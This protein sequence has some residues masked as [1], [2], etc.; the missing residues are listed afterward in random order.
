MQVFEE[1]RAVAERERKLQR[2]RERER[3]RKK[4]QVAR[5]GMGEIVRELSV[6]AKVLGVIAADV[7]R[8]RERERGLHEVQ[9][10]EREKERERESAILSKVIRERDEEREE[11]RV[12]ARRWQEE[13]EGEVKVQLEEREREMQALR[14]EILEE[15]GR[16]IERGNEREISEKERLATVEAMTAVVGMVQKGF[17]ELGDM[18]E[19]VTCEFESGVKEERETAREREREKE[20]W[21]SDVQEREGRRREE[22]ERDRER[23]RETQVG[24][25][26]QVEVMLEEVREMSAALQRCGSDLEMETKKHQYTLDLLKNEQEA[27]WYLERILDGTCHKYAALLTPIE[28]LVGALDAALNDVRGAQDQQLQSY[29]ARIHSTSNLCHNLT[30]E[31][32]QLRT[33]VVRVSGDKDEAVQGREQLLEEK[34]LLLQENRFL[35]VQFES[36]RETRRELDEEVLRLSH[37]EEEM[38]EELVQLRHVEEVVVQLQAEKKEVETELLLLYSEKEEA[39]DKLEGFVLALQA[40]DAQGRN[41]QKSALYSHRV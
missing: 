30:Y 3:E 32:R 33:N 37:V 23:Q 15:R 8:E 17:C 14:E 34:A 22:S 25:R 24:L 2:E 38:E 19:E 1:G 40:K 29:R 12:R 41:P 21:E 6:V 10:S 13:R 4:V 18:L 11:T 35:E 36:E 5:D 27:A 9:E 7:D 16:A 39:E 20:A 28:V 31:L 26:T